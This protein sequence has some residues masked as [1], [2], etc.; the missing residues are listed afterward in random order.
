MSEQ[1]LNAIL[2]L[3]G[4]I[5]R[6]DGVTAEEEQTVTRFLREEVSHQDLDTYLNVFRK[7]IT[8]A[9]EQTDTIDEICS[10][11]NQEQSNNQKTIIVIR[12]MEMVIADGHVSVKENE[13]LYKISKQL[14]FSDQ[15][16]DLIKQFVLATHSASVDSEHMLL[17]DDGEVKSSEQTDSKWII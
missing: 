9:N 4:L 12:L 1:V 17:I 8:L 11:V 13:L 10:R 6:E 16:T 5:A 14:Y 7:Y 15:V 3:L 2:Q